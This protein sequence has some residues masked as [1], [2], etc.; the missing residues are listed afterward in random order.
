MSAQHTP[1]LWSTMR[2]VNAS[3]DIAVVDAGGDILAECYSDI[4]RVNERSE[5]TPHNARLI[6]AAPELLAA[7]Q[8]IVPWIAKSTAKEGG[9]VA[10]SEAVLA[11]DALR[12]A[13]AK[14]TGGTA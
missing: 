11:A 4:R 6:A 5:E 12:D 9:A 1:G 14:A 10:Y 2:A 3:G 7:A 13:I 8:R